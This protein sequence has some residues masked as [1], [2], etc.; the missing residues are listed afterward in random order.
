MTRRFTRDDRGLGIGLVVF[1]S[2]IALVAFL[3]AL[4]YLEGLIP[5]FNS[6]ESAAQT[7]QGT[8]QI[9][10]FKSIA[11]AMGIYGVA[12]AVL[13]LIARSVVESRGPG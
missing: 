13:F 7:Q 10:E 12:V 6:A 5:M 9:L 8:D 3:F 2:M 4:L 11:T 1:A